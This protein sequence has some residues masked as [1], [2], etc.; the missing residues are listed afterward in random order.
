MKNKLVQAKEWASDNNL[1]SFLI[2]TGIGLALGM[3][4]IT[5]L[6]TTELLNDLDKDEKYS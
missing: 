2:G 5:L 6:D 4:I 3:V 1:P